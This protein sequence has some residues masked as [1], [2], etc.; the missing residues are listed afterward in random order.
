MKARDLPEIKSAILALRQHNGPTVALVTDIPDSGRIDYAGL[1][2]AQA[3]ETASYLKSRFVAARTGTI[4]VTASH[5]GFRGEEL[6]P[7]VIELAF[8]S[9]TPCHCDKR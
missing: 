8:G 5:D 4:L 7:M 2:N 3:G 9:Q 1:D 6:F